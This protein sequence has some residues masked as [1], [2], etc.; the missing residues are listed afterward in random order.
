MSRPLYGLVLAGGQSRRMGHDKALLVRDGQSQL[1]FIASLVDAVTDKFF[2]SARADQ[3]SDP[4]RSQFETIVD[5]YDDMGPIAGI[6]SAMDEHP[7]ADWLVIACD[8]PNIDDATLQFLLEHRSAEHPFTAYRSSNDGLPE[9]LCAIYASGSDKLIRK[10][11]D[12]GIFCPRKVL[13][14]SDTKLLDQPNPVALDNINTP[15]DLAGSVLEA[16][17]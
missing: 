12:D 16:M 6:L 2:V 5:R 15:A 1:R 4:E 11:V 8:L 9:P 14:N 7:A 17:S 10:F 13:I 3:Q